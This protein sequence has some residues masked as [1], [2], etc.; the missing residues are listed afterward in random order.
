MRRRQFIASAAALGATAVWSTPGHT[1]SRTRWRE[2]R[3]AFP[4]GV[5]SGDPDAHSVLLW[6]RRAY[7]QG[8]PPACLIVEVAEDAAF[9]RVVAERGFK[10]GSESDWTCRVLIGGLQPAQ[11]YF[12]RFTDAQGAGSRIGRTLTAPTDDDARPVRFAFVSCQ[13]VN[14]G[15]QHA[16]RRMIWDDE[17]APREQQLGFVL[18]LGDFIY[19]LVW[20]SPDRPEG[21][22][23]RDIRDILRYPHGE[24]IDDFHIPTTTE[25]YRAVYRAYLADA[26]IQDARARWPFVTMWD[27]HEFSWLG[28]QGLQKFDGA[29]R[30]AQT[31]K[32]AANQAW[33]EYAPARVRQPA[34]GLERFHPPAVRDAA[35]E[36]FDAEGLGLEPNNL[37]AIGSLTGYRALRWGAHVDLIITDQHSYRSED[38]LGRAQAKAFESPDFPELVPEE[39][40]RILDAASAWN[41]GKPPAT[42]GYGER[43]IANFRRDEPPQTV[44]GAAQKMWF[45]NRLKASRATWKIWANT[46]ATLDMRADPQNLPHGITVPWPGAG[47]AG[48]GGG[49]P[50]SAYLERAEIYDWI[51]QHRIDGFATI[52]GDR[53]SFWAGLAAKS[54]PPAAFEPVGIAFV[55]GSLSAPGMVEAHEHKF[56]KQHPLRPLF[57]ADRAG[58]KPEPTVNLLLKHGVKSALEYA[59]SADAAKARSLSNPDNAPHVAFVDMG[60]HGFAVV[61]ASPSRFD[62]EFVCIPRPTHAIAASDGGPLRYRVLHRADKWNAGERP[63]LTQEIIEGDPG[64]SV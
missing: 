26:D 34:G 62:A 16:W 60:G 10:V 46:A 2:Q 53:H 61:T 64:L 57:L 29:T 48:F 9:T 38:P 11:E 23:D 7:A 56:P 54:L 43:Q 44:L 15:A 39:A 52:A 50:S 6:T 22:Y 33:F 63:V 1:R 49:D 55:T 58:A 32:V 51:A 12:Y 28:W 20:Y 59:R 31:R 21:M 27:N 4:Q 24:K 47:Y 37:A 18:H 35:V 3:D 30:P 41:D 40:Q 17:H 45:L 42:I 25:D 8:D 13:N 19:E 5:A 36:H 14:Y